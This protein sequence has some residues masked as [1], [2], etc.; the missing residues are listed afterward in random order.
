MS[1]KESPNRAEDMDLVQWR[2][3][4]GSLAQG[5]QNPPTTGITNQFV[6]GIF[7]ARVGGLFLMIVKWSMDDP[8]ING[9]IHDYNRYKTKNFLRLKVKGADGTLKT[10]RIYPDAAEFECAS[11]HASQ[12][13]D[14]ENTFHGI[15]GFSNLFSTPYRTAEPMNFF[16]VVS[17]QKL[18]RLIVFR[19]WI[20]DTNCEIQMIR[21]ASTWTNS[22][23]AE[24]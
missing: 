10:N 15:N 6:R 12:H 3:Y 19:D 9:R 8:I 14:D 23:V 17:L 16:A 1:E 24:I 5:S 7:E 13:D 2:P 22:T 20:P 4:S 11:L 21:L 18:D